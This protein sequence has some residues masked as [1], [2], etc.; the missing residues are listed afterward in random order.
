[1]MDQGHMK[2][3]M[4]QMMGGMLPPSFSKPVRNAMPCLSRNNT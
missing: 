4:Q 1:M 2:E 3:M